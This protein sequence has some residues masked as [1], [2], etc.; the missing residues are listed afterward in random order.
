M[1]LGG[2]GILRI[3]QQAIGYTY[4]FL[5]ILPQISLQPQIFYS[6]VSFKVI[7]NLK[8]NIYLRNNEEEKEPL[9]SKQNIITSRQLQ[10]K[11]F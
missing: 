7:S 2:G 10:N 11:E 6:F 9:F 8:L 4:D 1:V 3:W 5:K